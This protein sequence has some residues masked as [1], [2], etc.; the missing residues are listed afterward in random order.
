MSKEKTYIRIEPELKLVPVSPA[1]DHLLRELLQGDA[2]E[3]GDCIL[4][5]LQNYTGDLDESADID[6]KTANDISLLI[7][8]ARICYDINDDF[9]RFAIA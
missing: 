5:I 8:L 2:A 3:A 4:R 6:V 9:H 7:R 1:Q